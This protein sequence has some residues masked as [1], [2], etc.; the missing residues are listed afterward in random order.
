MAEKTRDARFTMATMKR[1]DGQ[2]TIVQ[3]SLP[4]KVV[5]LILGIVIAVCLIL[6]DPVTAGALL[7]LLMSWWLT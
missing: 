7:A 1:G 5:L 4:R 2:C 3:I 6:L